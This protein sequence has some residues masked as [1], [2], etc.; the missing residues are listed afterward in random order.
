MA[1]V[2]PRS[3]WPAPDVGNAFRADLTRLLVASYRHWLRRDLV[4]PALDA[5]GQARA[6]FELPQAVAAHGTEPDPLFYYGNRAALEL[7]ELSWPAFTALPSRQSAEAP[8]RAGREQLLAR[9][10]AHGFIEDYR[11]VR[12]SASGRRFRILAATLW[13]VSATDGSPAG[14]A[15]LIR[16]W[17]PL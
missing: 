16:A 12:V 13:T 15:V 3:P 4:D 1:A 9:V 10:R 7:F 6:L 17:E 5:V 8:A 2:P 14:Q 11:G